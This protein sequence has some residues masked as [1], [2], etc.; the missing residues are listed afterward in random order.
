MFISFLAAK[1]QLLQY[2]N[3]SLHY[4]SGY[5]RRL[6]CELQVYK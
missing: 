4:F 6:F 1:V 3:Q 5:I 2:K